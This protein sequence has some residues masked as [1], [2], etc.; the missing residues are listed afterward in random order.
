[1]GKKSEL[2]GEGHPVQTNQNTSPGIEKKRP[3]LN[4]R[5]VKSGSAQKYFGANER[6]LLMPAVTVGNWGVSD[7]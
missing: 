2:F 7:M 1:M 5:Q 4:E 6:K 3:P